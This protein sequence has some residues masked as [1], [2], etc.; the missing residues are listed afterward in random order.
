MAEDYYKILGIEKAAATDDIKKA[1]RKLALK[2]HPDRNP[3][4]KKKAEEQFKKISEAYAV[5]SDPE[6]R[7][8]YDRFGSEQFTEKFSQEDI[9]RGFD[10]NEILKDLGFGGRGGESSFYFDFGGPGKRTRQRTRSFEDILGNQQSQ[11]HYMP[12][13]GDDLQ[14]NLSISLEEVV[15]GT[16]KKISLK[17][18]TWIEDV[19]VKIPSGIETG[20]KLRLAGKGLPGVDGGPPGDLFLNINVAP[21]GIFRR[22]GDDLYV[23]IPIKYSDAALGTS[24]G[25]PTLSGA[26]KRI[27][28]APG[29][30]DR[31]KIRMKGFGIPHFKESGRGDQYVSISIIVPKSLNERQ[32]DLLRKLAEEGL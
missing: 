24:V 17:K 30:Q 29:T 9:F 7:Q 31:T 32:A 14:Y 16:D 4:D 1:Y 25:V 11:H 5:L 28:V 15:K 8:Q 12:Q 27:K 20:Q 3:S 10:L 19:N 2:Y 23:D 6:K 18:G 21:H 13:K 22:E 26:M